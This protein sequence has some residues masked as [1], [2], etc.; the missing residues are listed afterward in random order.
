M[1]TIRPSTAL[2]NEYSEISRT[3]HENGEPIL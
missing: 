3:C 1:T 2:R